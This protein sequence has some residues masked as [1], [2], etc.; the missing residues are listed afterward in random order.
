MSADRI[1]SS[2]AQGTKS[3][4]ANIPVPEIKG[5]P[6]YEVPSG[7]SVFAEGGASDMRVTE[8]GVI[9]AQRNG[10]WDVVVPALKVM[11]QA[12][13]DGISPAPNTFYFI[14]A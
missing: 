4:Y 2:N 13:Y 9:E 5:V 12:Q 7:S 11:T 8:G 3:T 6:N 14:I 1:V 10:V